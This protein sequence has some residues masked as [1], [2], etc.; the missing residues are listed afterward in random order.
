MI[1]HTVSIILPT[2]NEELTLGKTIDEIPRESLERDGYEVDVLVVDN[3]STDRSQQIAREK[4]ARVIFQ[5]MRGK[6]IAVR[7]ALETVQADFIIMLDADYTYPA[8]YIPEMLHILRQGNKFVAG[9][10]F[11]GQREKGAIR[12]LNIVGNI[13]LTLMANILYGKRISDLCTGFWGFRGETVP[14]L[15][16]LADGFQFEAKLFTEIAK[17][18]YSITDVPIFYRRRQAKTKINRIRDGFKIGWVLLSR[19]FR[20]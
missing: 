7:T 19:R 13:L 14:G 2:L 16:L 3:G 8:S 18:G 10:R 6:G 9:S 1:N 11:K 4:G 15:N 5:P 20:R 17:Q 12:R